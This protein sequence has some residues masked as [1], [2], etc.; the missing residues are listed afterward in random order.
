[1]DSREYNVLEGGRIQSPLCQDSVS[2]AL[3]CCDI[4]LTEW[5][6]EAFAPPSP[7]GWT[8]ETS[9]V[10]AEAAPGIGSAVAPVTTSTPLGKGLTA[11]MCRF[12][13]H[14]FGTKHGQ[15]EA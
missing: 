2:G 7:W 3:C 12:L 15:G 4:E 6:S 5:L 10:S 1:M 13:A 11:L 9:I 14:T 8:P